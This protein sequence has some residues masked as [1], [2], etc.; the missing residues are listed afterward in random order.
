MPIEPSSRSSEDMRR[1]EEAAAVLRRVQMDSAAIGGSLLAQHDRVET[2]PDD[3]IG[4]LGKRI[5][6]ILGGLAVMVILWQLVSVLF[7]AR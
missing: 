4:V 1:Q 7:A 3:R 6:R 5:G 2:D